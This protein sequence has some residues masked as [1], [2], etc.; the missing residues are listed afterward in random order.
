[1]ISQNV[2]T[3]TLTRSPWIA[4]MLY[5]A[6]IGGL[7]ATAGFAIADIVDHRRALDRKSVV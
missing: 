5:V 6:V 3:R 1:M 7:L 2:I 4:V